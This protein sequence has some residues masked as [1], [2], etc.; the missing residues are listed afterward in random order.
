MVREMWYVI[1]IFPAYFVLFIKIISLEDQNKRKQWK[2]EEVD[3][4]NDVQRE[5]DVTG[6][7]EEVDETNE[8][9]DTDRENN[10]IDYHLD[11]ELDE[12]SVET[13]DSSAE[14]E[15]NDVSEEFLGIPGVN[16]IN[17]N[18]AEPLEEVH[19]HRYLLFL[20]FYN[21]S[22]HLS[23]SMILFILMIFFCY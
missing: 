1:K 6:T 11:M 19:I 3:E 8:N 10:I 15:N 2:D 17:D 4:G 5:F 14:K 23:I 13:I 16:E 22:D 7:L 21:F 9:E 12:F 18:S 20:S